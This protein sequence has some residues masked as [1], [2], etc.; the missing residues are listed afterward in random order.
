MIKYVLIMSCIKIFNRKIAACHGGKTLKKEP[1]KMA[2]TSMT[3]TTNRETDA[4]EF[5]YILSPSPAGFMYPLLAPAVVF[6]IP[7]ILISIFPNIFSTIG[8]KVGKWTLLMGG[9]LLAALNIVVQEIR[10]RS[11]K[12]KLHIDYMVL[13][14]GIIF[15]SFSKIYLADI[16]TTELTKT[17][18][19]R[20]FNLGTIRI[21][22]AGTEGYEMTLKRFSNP[23]GIVKYLAD[24]RIEGE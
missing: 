17:L 7:Y 9:L 12:L 3:T 24:H 10:R 13:S 8:I 11:V 18:F 1:M 15:T 22:T 2:K 5:D 20:I 4:E 21:A 19:E 6:L 14:K 16:K 23:A